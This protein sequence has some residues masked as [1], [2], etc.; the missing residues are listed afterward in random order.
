MVV[1][2]QYAS[3]KLGINIIPYN[4]LQRYVGGIDLKSAVQDN[5]AL[6]MSFGLTFA[7]AGFMS[8]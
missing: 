8:F 5:V 2:V 6:K 7:M 1:G 3:S 4:R